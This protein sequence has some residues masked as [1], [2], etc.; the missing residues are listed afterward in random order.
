MERKQIPTDI[1]LE[2][3]RSLPALFAYDGS[4]L[5][6]QWQEKAY[7]KLSELLGL[8]YGRYEKCDPKFEIEYEC[9]H[10]DFFETRFSFQSEE[11]Y[12]VPCHLLVPKTKADSYP[13]MICLQGHSTGMHISLGRAKHEGDEASINGGDRDFALTAVKNG[14]CA[15]TLE[16]R[17]MGECGGNPKPQ[18]QQT[19]MSSILIGRTL[20]GDRVWDISRLIDIIEKHFPQVDNN[21]IYC[22]GNSGG[23]TTTF[24]AACIEKR[25]KG[26][27]P[28]CS[29]CTFEDSIGRIFH[30]TCN[31]IP[32]IRSFFDMGDL[33]GLIAPRPL[34]IVSGAKDEIFPIDGAKKTFETAKELYTAAGAE[35]KCAHVIGP[36]GHRFYADESW[37]VFKELV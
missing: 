7:D 27:M 22:M 2:K 14:Y 4:E 10:S 9:D 8:K 3:M 18:C 19:A 5:F 1:E 17:C 35:D 36:E 31:Y 26:A 6:S 34:V 29:I 32:N 21:R 25:I 15:V 28:S 13:L 12:F 16:Q 24:Y 33:C 20:V 37:R 30:C 11:E 23:G